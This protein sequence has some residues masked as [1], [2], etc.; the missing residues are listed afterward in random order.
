MQQIPLTQPLAI[1]SLGFSCSTPAQ[2]RQLSFNTAASIKPP[3][4]SLQ[5]AYA[6]VEWVL[7]A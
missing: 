3:L 7:H 1:L 2:S 6:L 4:F 5:A